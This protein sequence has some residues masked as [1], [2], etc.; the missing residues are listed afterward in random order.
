M[1]T[2]LQASKHSSEYQRILDGEDRWLEGCVKLERPSPKRVQTP[3]VYLQSL[4]PSVMPSD[5]DV[6]EDRYFLFS[7]DSEW[8]H[9]TSGRGPSII[10]QKAFETS[11]IKAPGTLI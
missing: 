5:E 7:F 1:Y 8:T 10:S 9:N 2:K 3:F 11:S 4:E 6:I